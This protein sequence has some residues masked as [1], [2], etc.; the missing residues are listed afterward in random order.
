MIV[1]PREPTERMLAAM[2]RAANRGRPRWTYELFRDIWQAGYD[3][4][5]AE[6]IAAATQ[7]IKDESA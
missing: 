5:S 4:C 1:F 2:W 3:A 6:Q 7:P